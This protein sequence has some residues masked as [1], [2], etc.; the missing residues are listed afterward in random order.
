M[1]DIASDALQAVPDVATSGGMNAWGAGGDV[2]GL[3]RAILDKI[4]RD[5]I[6]DSGVIAG[7]VDKTLGQVS[8]RKARG[9]A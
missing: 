4:P 2:V 3:L 1:V 6:L 5:L 9:N 8:R 7:T